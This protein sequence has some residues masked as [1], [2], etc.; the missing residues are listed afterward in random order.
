[1]SKK[2]Y[3]IEG[4]IFKDGRGL[5]THVN[6]FVMDD[7]RRFYVIHQ[8]DTSVIRGWHAHKFEK[9]YFYVVKGALIFALVKID[10]WENPSHDLKAETFLLSDKKSDVLCVP[11]GY[12]NCVK[13]LEVNSEFIVFSNKTLSEAADDSWRYDKDLWVDWN[14]F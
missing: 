7:V 2:P 6:D 3:I 14:N 12:A 8:G 10:D 4:G 9:K 1:M 5:L 11:E 13:A